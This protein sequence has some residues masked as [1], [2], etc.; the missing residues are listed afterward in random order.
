M[1]ISELLNI[2]LKSRGVKS[3]TDVELLSFILDDEALSQEVSLHFKGS[4]KDIS[5]SELSRLRMVAGIGLQR[6][7]RILIAGEFGRRVAIADAPARGVI[8][9]DDD[10]VVL[11]KPYMEQLQ[12]EECWA[13]YLSSSNRI[14][15]RK[16][17]SQGGFNGVS[18][19]SRIIV[20]RAV[21]LLATH[22]I[23]IHNH[24][25]AIAEPSAQ[26][27]VLTERISKAASLFD[28]HLID[29]V[30]IAESASFSFRKSGLL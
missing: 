5:S 25:S 27:K 24:P 30:I 8:V 21:E 17:I 29:H 9:T 1:A 23:L 7:Q 6:A 3:L 14:I 20:K 11:F 16:C 15:E 26:D 10:V 22:I 28:I 18:V 13:L 12:H 4:M 2:K 19:D